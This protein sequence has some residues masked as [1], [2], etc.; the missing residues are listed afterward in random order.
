MIVVA[1]C[2][3]HPGLT[4]VWT[5]HRTR[6][7]TKT[8]QTLK[9][10]TSRP[11][12]KPHMLEPRNANG[13]QEVR[14]RNGSVI[15]FGA[16]EQGFGRGFD[17]IDMAVFDEAQILSEKGLE[18]IVPTTNQS[19][20]PGGALL[21]FMG[22]PPRPTDPGAEFSNRRRSAIGGETEDTVYVEFSADSDADLDDQ[23]QW[24]RANPSFPA[25][26]PVASMKRM[27]ANLTDDDSFRREALGIWDD[28]EAGG[29]LTVTAWSALA[30]VEV[31]VRPLPGTVLVLDVAPGHVSASIT[32]CANDGS[33]G[34]PVLELAEKRAGSSWLPERAAELVEHYGATVALNSSGPVGA[35]I[36]ELVR[37]GVEFTDVRGPDYSKACGRIVA[38]VNASGFRH[39]GDPDFVTAVAGAK[40][41]KNGDGFTWSRTD[42]SVDISPLIGATVALWAVASTP[43]ESGLQVF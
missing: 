1:L 6:T 32:A 39:D 33:R 3:I 35:L 27:R 19:E 40:A 5:A 16:R 12:V 30:D 2:L 42:S 25:R 8:F 14:F 31:D 18:D 9:A 26:T 43:E 24:A 37:L 36:P 10:M 7:A 20:M 17:K 38:M 29:H 28:D 22:T 15:M 34:M 23:K 13:E 21:F 41:R 4:V 11:K